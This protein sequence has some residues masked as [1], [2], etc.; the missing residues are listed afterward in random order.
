TTICAG[1]LTMLRGSRKLAYWK[2]IQTGTIVGNDPKEVQQLSGLPPENFIETMY[3]FPEPLA[4][5]QAAKKWGKTISLDDMMTTFNKH[6]KEGTFL[7]LE[8]AGGVF[9]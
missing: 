1:L 8:G 4:P 7:V 5:H 9:T 3:R 2:P 6:V